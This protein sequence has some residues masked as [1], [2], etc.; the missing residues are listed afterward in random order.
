[1]KKGDLVLCR[2][3]GAIG[4][5]IGSFGHGWDVVF[6]NGYQFRNGGYLEVINESR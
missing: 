4:I 2:N 5:I 6:A 3:S 1:M